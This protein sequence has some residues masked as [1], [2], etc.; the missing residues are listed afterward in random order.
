LN[1]DIDIDLEFLLEKFKTEY[2]VSQIFNE[3]EENEPSEDLKRKLFNK[4]KN[5]IVN[6]YF[7]RYF[8]DF[9]MQ[10][11]PQ[12]K[13][14]LFGS[15]K[16]LKNNDELCVFGDAVNF[17]GSNQIININFEEVDSNLIS[18][19]IMN[20]KNQNDIDVLENHNSFLNSNK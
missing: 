3:D 14:F 1:S 12:K 7:S 19:L 15:L 8:I 16:L 4:E 17:C 10:K 9:F 13:H 11:K 5:S 6:E 20:F 2:S 18:Q